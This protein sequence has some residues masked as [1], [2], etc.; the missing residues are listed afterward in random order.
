MPRL[1]ILAVND[2]Y[3]LEHLPRLTSLVRHHEACDPAERTLVV[4]AGD[5]VAPSLLS[6]LDSG[7]GMVDCLNHVPI[8]HA[9]LGNH[10][11]DIGI[12][13]LR[14]RL[15]ELEATVL[16]TNVHGVDDSLPKSE[17][18]DVGGV[19]VGLIGVTSGEPS[20]YRRPPFGGARV[21]DANE[22]ARRTADALL[23]QG[24][25]CVVAIT[26]QRADDDRALARTAPP[27][28]V[29]VGGHEHGG[30]L[31]RVGAT[32]IVK[33]PA[34]AVQAS[35]IE[36]A[37]SSEGPAFPD[38]RV[39]FEDV[40]RHPEDAAMRARVDRHM[41]R[42]RELDEATLLLLPEG[43]TL[44]SVGARARQTSM[45]ELVCSRLRDVFEADAAI[46]NG[47]GI[48]GG[49]E[50]EGRLT[51]GD[52][53]RE[54]PFENEIVVVPLPGAVLRDAVAAS[55][56]KAP[57]ESGSFLQVD[58][59]MRVDAEH[60]VTHVAGRPLDPAA[61]Y[62][63]ALVRNF[64]EGMDDIEPLVRFGREHPEAVPPE[65]SG[66]GVKIALVSAFAAMLLEQLGGFEGVDANRDGR[67]TRGELAAAF[68]RKAGSRAGAEQVLAALDRDGD[69]ALT[70]DELR[71]KS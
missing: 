22:A 57:A 8:T 2:V 34:D 13:E 44:S 19:R 48:R 35:V 49:R 70:S 71:R 27:F 17:V 58:D 67:V 54:L 47:G 15:R 43:R 26:H 9:I 6:S 42:V 55:R 16:L 52:L 37:W 32:W 60:R 20:L 53:E 65:A 5:F 10:E 62:R 14:A 31:E 51:Y 1:R 30:L 39:R 18:L 33:A 12:E 66:R 24:C 68:E 64:L 50:Y 3:T 69:G 41:A 56:A 23:A 38:V 59:G 7:R 46:F 36:L 45:G 11:D 63:V 4:M 61:T 40:A 21:E 29:I 25:A 28:P